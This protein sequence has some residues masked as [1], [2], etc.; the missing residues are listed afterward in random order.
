MQKTARLL[1][2]MPTSVGVHQVAT[3]F[4][5]EGARDRLIDG[6]RVILLPELPPDAKLVDFRVM[7]DRLDDG[8]SFLELRGRQAVVVPFRALNGLS[9]GGIISPTNANHLH[10]AGPVALVFVRVP[11][12]Q[13]LDGKRIAAVFTVAVGV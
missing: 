2:P 10:E 8:E 12:A 6:D 9:A 1:A 11:K 7:V 3:V 5:F 4:E 13:F